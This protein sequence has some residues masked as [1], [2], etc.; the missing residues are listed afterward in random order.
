M[1]PTPPVSFRAGEAPFSSLAPPPHRPLLR[2]LR[3]PHRPP[4]LLRTLAQSDTSAFL[5][6]PPH[7]LSSQRGGCAS[8][9]CPACRPSSRRPVD[10]SPLILRYSLRPSAL[11]PAALG[12]CAF[13]VRPNRRLPS[14]RSDYFILVAHPAC[15]LSSQRLRFRRSPPHQPSVGLLRPLH[16]GYSCFS[17]TLESSRLRRIGH[18]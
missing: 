10:A 17:C 18:H 14:Q 2:I 15:Q 6:V 12:G 7:R 13:V 9:D 11:I 4:L 16:I 5:E 3:P 1:L 8:V